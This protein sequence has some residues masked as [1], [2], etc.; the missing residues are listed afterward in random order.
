MKIVYENSSLLPLRKQCIVQGIGQ[1]RETDALRCRCMRV[2]VSP[3]HRR[4]EIRKVQIVKKVC[5]CAVRAQKYT[6]RAKR[7]HA[8]A[9]DARAARREM[10]ARANS[11]LE[12]IGIGW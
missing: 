4:A 2:R 9:R 7:F 3:L 10:A 11:R 12:Y 5:A 6:G 8:P 1:D